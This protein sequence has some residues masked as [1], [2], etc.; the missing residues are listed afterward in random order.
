[1]RYETRF[2]QRNRFSFIRRALRPAPL[3]GRSFAAAL[4]AYIYSSLSGV[5]D[6][7]HTVQHIDARITYS[8]VEL[9]LPGLLE[10][11][12]KFSTF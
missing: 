9:L 4:Q 2:R 5:Q 10:N 1:M 12:V 6:L 7:P 11:G 3:L 8:A